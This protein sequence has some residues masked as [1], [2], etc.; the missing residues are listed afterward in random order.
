MPYKR[1]VEQVRKQ[2]GDAWLGSYANEVDFAI[3]PKWHYDTDNVVAF[4][5]KKAVNKWSGEASLKGKKVGW[6]RGYAFDDYFKVKV[7]KRELNSR[8]SALRMLRKGRID[9]FVDADVEIN[10]VIRKQKF[11]KS[12]YRMETILTLN[13][14][15]AF[16][17]TSR[18]KKLAEIWDQRI[19]EL[20]NS[21]KLKVL[22]EKSEYTSYPTFK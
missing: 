3:Y 2:K 5:K 13:L 1:T 12:G 15:L 20:H 9:F 7:K 10:N 11:D 19:M 6:L 18:G 17:N 16:A 8:E 4:F 21:G 14:Y 22:Y